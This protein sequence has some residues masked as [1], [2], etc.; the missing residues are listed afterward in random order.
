MTHQKEYFPIAEQIVDA[1]CSITQVNDRSFFRNLVSFTLWQVASTMRA[2]I[3]TQAFGSNIPINGYVL[4][5]AKQ[6]YS[7]NK[8][9]SILNERVINLFTKRFLNATL[10]IIVEDTLNSLALKEAI[11]NNTDQEEEL[12]KLQKEY[13]SFGEFLMSFDSGTKEGFKQF[14]RKQILVPIGSLNMIMDELGSNIMSVEDLLKAY[15]ETYD[16]GDIKEKLVKNTKDNVRSKERNGS[17]PCNL[18]AF[19]EPTKLLDGDKV[20]EHF[21]KLLFTGFARR[22]LFGFGKYELT[23]SELSAKELF[24]QAKNAY[25][26]PDLPK[27]SA[28]F[29]KLA[30]PINFNKKILI[31]ENAE[32]KLFDYQKNCK[33][34]AKTLAEHE[35]LKIV[36]LEHRYWKVLKLAGA[37]AFVDQSY[38]IS[39]LHIDYAINLVEDSGEAFH[40]IL[41]RE[42]PYVR[43]AKY[44]ASSNTAMTQVDLIEAGVLK[45]SE[46]Q[47]RELITLAIAYGYKNNIIIKRFNIDG[48]DFILGE[49]L[50]ETNLDSIILSHST[51]LADGYNP[52]IVKWDKIYKGVQANNIH[53]CNHH[54]I[55]NY[56]LE[57]NAIPGFN[58]VVLDIDG[59]I[60]L[61]LVH[62]LLKDYTFLTYTTKRHTEDNNRFRLILP[63]SHEVRLNDKDFTEYMKNVCNWLPF[64]VDNTHQRSKK[65]LS[66]PSHYHYNEGELLDA[67]QFIPKTSKAEE[68][69]KRYIDSSSL[70][71]LERWYVN[72]MEEGNRS[73]TLIKYALLLVDM[74]LDEDTIQTKIL[75]L[76]NKLQNK[77]D[78]SE[79][80]ITIMRTVFK[81]I[82]K[83]DA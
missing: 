81:A 45:G 53:W 60:S 25:N 76:N 5:L 42:Q 69:K 3:H 18:L 83:R 17:V 2:S 29:E 8:S 77:L 46:S 50:K 23:V 79:I 22:F 28:A 82:A 73:N 37:Y 39:E 78:E 1:Q 56:R 49:S 67:L 36:E 80:Q 65:W 38:L 33:A 19:G 54:F 57:K 11:K 71:N 7:K 24:E 52:S 75:N 20:E 14:R 34:L 27:I 55:D 12:Q 72:Q 64:E 74:G 43:L 40:R 51:Q 44:L 41:T 21:D 70:S 68:N 62:T 58:I 66:N 10:P 26:N 32:I 15:L 31:E 30:D 16:T 63:I 9:L 61:D 13:D 4:N 6:G 48:I 59:S 47:K 35:A